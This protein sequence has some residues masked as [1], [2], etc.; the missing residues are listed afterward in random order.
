MDGTEIGNR[1]EAR[2]LPLP[3]PSIRGGFFDFRGNAFQTAFQKNHV[4]H[5]HHGRQHERERR[6]Q[7]PQRFHDEEIRN[8]AARKQHNDGEKHHNSAAERQIFFAERIRRH[9]HNGY[10]QNRARYRYAHRYE[11]A[12]KNA[13]VENTCL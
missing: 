12:R 7:E 8:D 2:I 4:I 13:N 10:R 1:M 11:N 5:L 9:E 3:A 6:I